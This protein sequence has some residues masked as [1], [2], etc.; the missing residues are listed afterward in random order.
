MSRS[1]TRRSSATCR[2]PSAARCNA[3]TSARPALLASPARRSR[4]RWT[5]SSDQEHH[6]GRSVRQPDGPDGLRIR[7]IRLADAERAGAAVR[8][9]GLHPGGQ[10][11]LARTWCCT[12]RAT[13][14]SSSTASR[15]AW[16]RYFAAEHGPSR[17]A[18]GLPRTRFAQGLCPCAGAGRTAGGCPHRSDGA[19]PAGDQG[20]RRRAAVP[21]RPLRGRQ[22]RSTTSTSSSC[23]ASSAIPEATASSSST[24]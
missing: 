2:R 17:P 16:P 11:S 10:A 14:T 12:A 20:H 1:P 23:R 6:H 22:V 9:D 21:D 13:S 19:A 4:S 24:T 8:E 18:A 15:R 3:A 5:N 7:R